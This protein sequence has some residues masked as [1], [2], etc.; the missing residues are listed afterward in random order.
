MS[1]P[2]LRVPRARRNV[3]RIRGA[4]LMTAGSADGADA[5]GGCSDGA[6]CRARRRGRLRGRGHREHGGG[7]RDRDARH[8]RGGRATRHPSGGGAAGRLRVGRGGI[9]FPRVGHTRRGAFARSGPVQTLASLP[10]SPRWFR[11][12]RTSNTAAA[13]ALADG[14]ADF[15][16]AL[17]P[18]GT[19][20]RLGLHL[21]TDGVADNAQ[22]RHPVRQ[23]R[24]SA[25]RA[26]SDGC[27]QDHPGGAPADGSIGCAA[28]DAGAVRRPRGESVAHRVTPARRQGQGSIPSRSMRSRTSTRR[29]WPR[30]WWASSARAPSWSFLAPTLP[31]TAKSRRWPPEQARTTSGDAHAW[32]EALR[33]GEQ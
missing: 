1:A 24:A 12:R 28:R 2:A 27:R 32:V 18:P 30:R 13:V 10:P 7:R 5:R 3:H 21:V 19:A 4:A 17:A 33:R 31:P 14:S 23:G 6:R 15:D 25:A 11:S 16:A 22:R 26:P 29:V 8:A 9:A 20:E